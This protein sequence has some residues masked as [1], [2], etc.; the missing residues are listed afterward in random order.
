MRKALTDAVEI[1]V[2]RGARRA[3]RA[4]HPGR[5]WRR[6]ALLGASALLAGS[7][8]GAQASAQ[9]PRGVSGRST[10][11]VSTDSEEAL[12]A[13]A[14][15]GT[16]YAR[17]STARAFEL[18]ATEPGSREEAETYRRLFRSDS[19]NC[20]G[21]GM[22]LRV[23]VTFVRGAI[24]EGL[25]EHGIAV[26]AGLVRAAPA[27][28]AEIRKYSEAARCYAAGH[29]AEIRTMLASSPGGE[30]E[31]AALRPLADQFFRCMPANA[32]DRRFNATHLRYMLAEAL[33]RLPSPSTAQA[34][35]R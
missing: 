1:A 35:Q 33:L 31:L 14:A 27:P 22:D 4:R 21:E 23:P 17:L 32:Q 15:F 30:R 11:I 13:L 20:L 29:G 3:L 2:P 6:R 16:C 10:L 34:A 9:L 18:L 19:Q 12:R 28:G 5:A 25:L 26:P 8:L 7:L 24:A